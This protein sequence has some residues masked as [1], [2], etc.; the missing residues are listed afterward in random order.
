[1]A[2]RNILRI[3]EREDAD[4]SENF[5]PWR[6]VRKNKIPNRARIQFA[7][8]GSSRRKDRCV[9]AANPKMVRWPQQEHI[10]PRTF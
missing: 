2:S 7:A 8:R 9:R 5:H 10:A 3:A 6:R 1:M 4:T